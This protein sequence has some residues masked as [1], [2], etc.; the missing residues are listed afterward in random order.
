[1]LGAAVR[2]RCRGEYPAPPGAAHR[3]NAL[4]GVHELL[5]E[6]P[7]RRGCAAAHP[8]LLVDVLDVM[9]DGLRRDAEGVAD[10]LVGVAAHER[11]QHLELAW[12]QP[13]RQLAWALGDLMPGCRKH[14]RHGVGIELALA[15]L[16]QQ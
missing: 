15:R 6:G 11:E 5:L 10:R 2:C 16:A 4:S 12:R 7:Q 13:G 3:A 8:G 9:P 1:M 14:G